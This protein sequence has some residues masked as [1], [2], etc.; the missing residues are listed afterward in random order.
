LLLKARFTYNEHI[1]YMLISLVIYY[2]SSCCHQ[3]P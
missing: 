3:V 1:V 2:C